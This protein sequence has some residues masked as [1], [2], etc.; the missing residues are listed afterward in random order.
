NVQKDVQKQLSDHQGF[1]L[2]MIG[3]NPNVTME[4]M[5]RKT[6]V[7]IKTI[8]RDRAAIHAVR[9]GGRKDGYWSVNEQ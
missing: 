6:G 5:S 7:S 4:E 9:K 2:G 8:Q 3:K 1:L